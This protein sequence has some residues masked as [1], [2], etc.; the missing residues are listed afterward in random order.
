M[1]HIISVGVPLD[2]VTYHRVRFLFFSLKTEKKK[3]TKTDSCLFCS[4]FLHLFEMA[5]KP[6]ISATAKSLP[7]A[8]AARDSNLFND[9]TSSLSLSLC[10]FPIFLF[11][12]LFFL[13]N[14]SPVIV[15][16]CVPTLSVLTEN[17]P[18]VRPSAHPLSVLLRT[19]VLSVPATHFWK[20]VLSLQS[21]ANRIVESSSGRRWKGRR[22][23][24]RGV[25]DRS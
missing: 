17:P 1:C 5:L 4:C 9:L 19:L 7:V 21:C 20:S 11:F 15:R 14:E 8:G 2:T 22:R 3:K 24:S 13:R 18:P 23:S 12:L 10:V 25:I 6:I 16:E